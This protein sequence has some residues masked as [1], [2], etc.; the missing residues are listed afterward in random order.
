MRKPSIPSGSVE[1][2]K[3]KQKFFSWKKRGHLDHTFRTIP[4]KAKCGV[5]K[6]PYLARASGDLTCCLFLSWLPVIV[7]P[8]VPEPWVCK[9]ELEA[10]R[11]LSPGFLGAQLC[12]DGTF[13]VRFL[14]L[15]VGGPRPWVP[16]AKPSVRLHPLSTF[17]LGRFYSGVS[18]PGILFYLCLFSCTFFLS[19]PAAKHNVGPTLEAFCGNIIFKPW[20]RFS[21]PSF[22]Q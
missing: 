20:N 17:H 4:A 18:F 6:Q 11:S 1:E 9:G 2:K 5:L 16:S 12:K 14:G 15:G 10:K 7:C 13:L 21:A 8:S 3:A 19:S 22:P